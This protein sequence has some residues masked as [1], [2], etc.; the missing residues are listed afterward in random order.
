MTNDIPKHK[1]ILSV[2]GKF[3]LEKQKTPKLY[4]K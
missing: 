2:V 4:N 1:H 3:Y